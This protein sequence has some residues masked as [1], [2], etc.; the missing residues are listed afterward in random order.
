MLSLAVC[1]VASLA[2][3]SG[4]SLAVRSAASCTACAWSC[5][6]FSFIGG[7]KFITHANFTRP[8]WPTPM[9]LVAKTTL[10]LSCWPWQKCKMTYEKNTF[11]SYTWHTS[12]LVIWWNG[13]IC[14]V[15]SVKQLLQRRQF[16]L[17]LK[18]I[19]AVVY[20]FSVRPCVLNA[21]CNQVWGYYIPHQIWPFG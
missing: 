12:I 15:D 6:A 9:F 10:L 17:A 7:N 19:I 14:G 11:K 13:I 4:A 5:Y 18:W 3:C 20:Y 1:S 2:V 16:I 21:L 8:W